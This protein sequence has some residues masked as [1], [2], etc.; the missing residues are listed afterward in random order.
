MTAAK[1]TDLPSLAFVDPAEIDSTYRVCLWA[2][3]G[4]G[5]SV[6]AASAPGPI[7]ALSADRPSAYR[8]ARKHHNTEGRSKEIREVRYT[9]PDTLVAVSQ[10]LAAPDCDVRT[11]IIDPVSN[12]IDALADVAP[13]SRDGGPDYQWIN[14][15]VF[16]FVKSLRRFDINVVLVAHE[17]INDGK[18]GD[19]KLYPAL[20]GPALINKLLGEM[21]IVAHVERIVRQVEGEEE[22][23]AV[24]IGQIQPVNKLVG[25]DSTGAL[26]DRRVA[27]LSR[28]F[29]VADQFVAVDDTDL[30]WT[31][32]PADD[33]AAGEAE[34]QLDLD[35]AQADAA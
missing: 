5:K 18:G 21:D 33:D 35:E 3:P 14:K 34:A 29:E 27:D 25:K 11:V 10:Y 19:G 24:W 2:A 17:K 13:A 12:I 15:Q 23:R 28:W 31:G 22:A 9:G 26:G 6:A 8:F 4:E 30:P 20:G 1:T 16:R 7:L 32:K